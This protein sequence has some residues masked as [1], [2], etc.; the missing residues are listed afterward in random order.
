MRRPRKAVPGARD[1]KSKLG[2]NG[3]PRLLTKTVP[4]EEGQRQLTFKKKFMMKK[5]VKPFTKINKSGYAVMLPT[6]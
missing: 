1:L 3:E 5:K 4:G 2:S 6:Y